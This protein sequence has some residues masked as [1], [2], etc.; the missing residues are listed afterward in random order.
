MRPWNNE[1]PDEYAEELSP[2]FAEEVSSIMEEY[3]VSREEAVSR[4]VTSK[5]EEALK[6]TNISINDFNDEQLDEILSAIKE[7]DFYGNEI[8]EIAEPN[9]P[10]W[11]MEQLKWLID[12]WNKGETKV[13]VEKIQ[14]LKNLDIDIAKFNVL[15]GYLVNDEMS[16]E[17]IESFKENMDFVTMSEFVDSLKEIA[18][19]NEFEKVAIKVGN[20]FILAS[21]KD[22]FAISLEDTGRKV[23]VEGKEYSLNR[24]SSF[25]ESQKVDKLIDSGKYEAFKINDY[26]VESDT[27]LENQEA[28]QGNIF[29]YMNEEKEEAATESK[30]D[31]SPGRTVYMKHEAYS[32]HEVS[33]NEIIGK[34]DL[35]L[36]PVRQG[37]R[38]ILIVSFA[39]EKELLEKISFDR[40][41]LIVGDEVHYKDKDFTITRFDDMGSGLK[42][43]TIKDN[44]EYLGGMITGSEVIPYRLESDLERLFG[45]EDKPKEKASNFKITE[46]ILP[47]KLTPSERLNQNLEAISMLNRVERGEREL[48]S[49]AQEVLAKYVGW[50]GLSEVFDKEKGGQWETARKF[51]KE[52]LSPLEYE[53]AKESTLTAFFTPK[54]VIDGVYK[55][56]SDMGFKSGNILEPSMGVGNFIGNLPDEMNKSKFYG[57]ELDSVSGRIGKLLYPDS[58]IQVKGFEETSFSN[59]FFDVAIGNVPF[60]EF[61]VNDREYNRNNFLIHDYFFA[62]SIDKVRNGG[63]I[64]FITSSGTMD[65]K[66]ESIRKY[67]NARAEFLGAIRLPNDTFK[68]V[69]GTEV[70]SDIIFLKKRDSV[71]ER[72]E[73]WVHLAE[74]ENGLTYNKYFVEH[75][76]MVLG[77]MREVSGRFGNTISCIPKESADLR[78]SIEKASKKI[79]KDSKYE[80]IELLDDEITSIPATDDVKNFSYTVIDN[81]VYYRENSL[82]IK[83]EVSDKNKEKIKDYLKLNEA[84]KDVIKSQ[85]EDFSDEEIKSSQEKLNEVYDSFSKKHGFV[86][87]LSNT[88]ALREDS[89]FPLVSSIEILDEEDNFKT[90]GD[91]FSKR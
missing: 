56:L 82:F 77:T 16:I 30:L 23:V 55:S 41:K 76:E 14:Y 31:L 7:Y 18:S 52:N 85:K 88:R 25:E 48:D 63:V 90:K 4:L 26:A 38:Q 42:T 43:I 61:K 40:P 86:N 1:L 50:G 84:L 46:E 65:K 70:T 22:G 64:A 29:E 15:K 35:W 33:K 58:D 68:G 12:D 91:I 11:K 5:L 9:L 72:D 73:P 67:I 8:T 45:L 83:K 69:A 19:D 34:N 59:N 17:Q 28:V 62:K 20:E 6:G 87:N 79:S 39:D 74:D 53:A 24:G 66:D 81:D 51:L 54:T 37:N 57:V 60:G 80:E 36:D 89:N 10:V 47:E 78:E 32:I 21:K 75:P 2:N 44:A 13:T 27:Q 49:T 3:E 71:L